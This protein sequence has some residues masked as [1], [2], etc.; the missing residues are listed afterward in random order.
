MK[1]NDVQL[2]NHLTYYT[3]V[4]TNT[5]FSKIVRILLKRIRS[6]IDRDRETTTNILRDGINI[7]DVSVI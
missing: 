3:R 4:T 2:T 7:G 5:H 1:E 6:E